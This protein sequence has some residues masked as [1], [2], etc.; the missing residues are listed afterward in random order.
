MER[1]IYELCEKAKRIL[2]PNFFGIAL[3]ENNVYIIPHEMDER[4]KRRLKTL[5]KRLRKNA[6]KLNLFYLPPRDFFEFVSSTSSKKRKEN[7]I[8]KLQVVSSTSSFSQLLVHSI[9]NPMKNSS[10]NVDSYK[11]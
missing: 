3:Y 4:Q 1:V 11:L 5:N 10:L 6:P 8:K 9:Y 2:Q 7:F